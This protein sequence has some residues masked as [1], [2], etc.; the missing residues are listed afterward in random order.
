MARIWCVQGPSK[1]QNDQ[2]R[3]LVLSAFQAQLQHIVL[4]MD[5][6]LC[7]NVNADGKHCSILLAG[8]ETC[9][10]ETLAARC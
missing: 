6:V 9:S 8:L 10:T 4:T 1:G 5:T 2:S 7:C 3:S